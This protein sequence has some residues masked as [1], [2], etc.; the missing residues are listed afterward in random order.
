[1]L[2]ILCGLKGSGKSVG[3][4]ILK[5]QNYSVFCVD[6][7][8]HYIYNYGEIGYNAIKNKLGAEFVDKNQVRRDLINEWIFQGHNSVT[9]EN[10]NLMKLNS[11]MLPLI[12][13]KLVKLAEA[14]RKSDQVIFV[15][16]AIYLNHQYFFHDVTDA[17][18]YVKRDYLICDN[19]TLHAAKYLKP[20]IKSD[21][22]VVENNT[23]IS[24][25]KKNLVEQVDNLI[26]KLMR[27]RLHITTDVI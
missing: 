5:A 1:M 21:W 3:L 27:R 16:M 10:Q 24:Q 4:E 20:E 8:I 23:T 6:D 9:N 17:I 19:P 26:S 25:F 22:Y 7:W 11:V 15:E 14:A 12:K 13:A 18:I 2:V